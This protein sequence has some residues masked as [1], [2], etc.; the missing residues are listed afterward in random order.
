MSIHRERP[1][2]GDDLLSVLITIG[3]E[4]NE[5]PWRADTEGQ[6]HQRKVAWTVIFVSGLDKPQA[7]WKKKS[8][9]AWSAAR[10]GGGGRWN[11]H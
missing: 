9:Q 8:H 3:P 10:S 7:E 2:N 4:M 11:Q 6:G 1:A 5:S